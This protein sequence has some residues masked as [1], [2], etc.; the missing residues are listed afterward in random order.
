MK[1]SIGMI[2]LLFVFMMFFS[3]DKSKKNLDGE[4]TI[5]SENNSEQSY[6]DE[7]SPIISENNEINTEQFY[8]GETSLKF[9]YIN[10]LEGTLRRS[11]NIG[12][13]IITTISNKEAVE[14]IGSTPDFTVIDGIEDRWYFV[15]FMH[16]SGWIFGG[17]LSE[18][19]LVKNQVSEELILGI[20]IGNW[21]N[22]SNGDK[23]FLFEPDNKYTEILVEG[24]FHGI[25][26]L[27]QNTLTLTENQVTGSGGGYGTKTISRGPYI[28]NVPIF[29]ID[30]DT[31]V[32]DV[33][34]NDD[35]FWEFFPTNGNVFLRR[36]GSF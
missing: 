20:L 34:N 36:I 26:Q 33:S 6:I 25:W 17:D 4:K 21:E 13:D 22:V 35:H 32:F 23:G 16:L 28:Y 27:N 15:N 24:A 31:I 7:I 14:I 11:A 29:I 5:T 18:E 12:S 8:I 30:N 9:R 19:M 3:C 1:R 2:L 10:S